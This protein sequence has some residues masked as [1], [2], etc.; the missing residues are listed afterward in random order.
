MHPVPAPSLMASG[1][2]S[3]RERA[4]RQVAL[5]AMSWPRMVARVHSLP[6]K[7]V[8]WRRGSIG[9][10]L[11]QANDRTTSL[12]GT[13]VVHGKGELWGAFSAR[14]DAVPAFIAEC[15]YIGPMSRTTLRQ[16]ALHRRAA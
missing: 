5:L 14:R 4:H 15:K 6:V 8:Q 10:G 11:E 2:T 13:A 16:A 12:V 3:K 1:A 7:A 9:I